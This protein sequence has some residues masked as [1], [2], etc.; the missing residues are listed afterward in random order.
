MYLNLSTFECVSIPSCAFFDS[1]PFVLYGYVML[2][3][4]HVVCG[5]VL[6]RRC[7]C[8]CLWSLCESQR[9]L[10]KCLRCI[11]HN[12]LGP[13]GLR[14]LNLCAADLWCCRMWFCIS[15]QHPPTVIIY[16]VS[17]PIKQ[18]EFCGTQVTANYS[19]NEYPAFLVTR[20]LMK[21]NK[22]IWQ[23]NL[24]AKFFT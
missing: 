11:S 17:A 19:P 23:I 15:I 20:Q 3:L 6:L 22:R 9:R 13:N 5:E 10:H 16:T 14:L 4:M 2:P 8:V 18:T 1:L 7:E 24:P 21:K 12:S